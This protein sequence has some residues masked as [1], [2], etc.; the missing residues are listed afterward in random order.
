MFF[1][2]LYD[3]RAGFYFSVKFLT[4]RACVKDGSKIQSTGLEGYV[5]FR[6][7]SVRSVYLILWALELFS[8][9]PRGVVGRI[10]GSRC[11]YVIHYYVRGV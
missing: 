8:E 6:H 2:L 7:P 10:P 1:V 5:G 4:A 9:I 3:Q 11:V